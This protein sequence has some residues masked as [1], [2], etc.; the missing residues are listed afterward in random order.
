V[1]AKTR[2]CRRDDARVLPS[3]GQRP[4]LVEQ[5]C[6][7]RTA[8]L[9]EAVHHEIY[10]GALRQSQPFC[11]AEH[12]VNQ[13]ARHCLGG[14]VDGHRRRLVIGCPGDVSLV[15]TLPGDRL[16]GTEVT[17]EH[18]QAGRRQIV[19]KP[20]RRPDAVVIRQCLGEF[21]IH[22][23]RDPP[24]DEAAATGRGSFQQCIL[25]HS[26]ADCARILRG[27]STPAFD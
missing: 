27:T 1:Q 23:G 8:R 2:P 9:I 6:P 20:G 13:R 4:G 21:G 19:G 24:G 16:A 18:G 12:G 17:F 14:Q 3:H 11:R 5:L 10:A 26:G 22:V 7:A 15:D 25:P